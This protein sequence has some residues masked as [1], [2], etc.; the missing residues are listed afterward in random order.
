MKFTCLQKDFKNALNLVNRAIS[1]R[2]TLPVLNNVL[3]EVSKEK[4]KLSTTNLEVAITHWLEADVKS[5][6]KLTVPVKLLSQYIALLNDEKVEVELLE[7]DTISLKSDSSNTKI[8]GISAEEFPLIPKLE[9]GQELSIDSA[10]LQE[11]IRQTSFAAA[12]DDTRPV[13][14]GV[15]LWAQSNALILVATDS[16]RLAEKRLEVKSKEELK[17]IIPIK[18]IAELGRILGQYHEDLKIKV[19]SNQIMFEF[20]N[21]QLIS[22][23]IDGQYPP[24]EQI[25]PSTSQ[26]KLTVK[27]ETLT[28]VLKRVNLFAEENGHSVKFKLK[29]GAGLEVVADTDQ[30]GNETAVIK[31][32]Y[33]EGQELEIAFNALYLLEAL[34]NIGTEEVRL[35]FNTETS[36]GL[37]R[38]VGKTD[39]LHIVMPLKG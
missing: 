14:A 7:G 6:G 29:T 11:A 20:A 21:L 13:L 31:D 9:G 12:L 23:L 37:V 3:I 10:T 25:I 15:Y 32:A 5:E 4:V 26:S 27:T 19:T 8:K 28:Q 1:G 18:T 30:V 38:P 36:P 33:L 16:Y 35:E 22:R 34:A 17:V 39:Y 2:S 24:Y